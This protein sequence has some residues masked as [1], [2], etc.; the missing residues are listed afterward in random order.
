MQT[1]H[2]NVWVGA[3]NQGENAAS[4]NLTVKSNAVGNIIEG[5]DR[6]LFQSSEFSDIFQE[7]RS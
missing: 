5:F 4:A 3:F 1:Q 6:D 7:K 2:I